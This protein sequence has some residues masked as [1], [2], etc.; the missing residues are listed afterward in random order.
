[1]R[2]AVI[3]VILPHMH[4]MTSLRKSIISSAAVVLMLVGAG[5]AQTAKQVT[6]ETTD[7]AVNSVKVS[8]DALAKA[9]ETAKQAD[10][11]T[12]E[13]NEAASD[14][15]TVAWVLTEGSTTTEQNVKIANE[16][17]GCNDRVAFVKEHRMAETIDTVG[18]ALTTLFAL[19]SSVSHPGLYNSL[20]NSK[21][22]VDKILSPDGV[23]TEVWIAG[24]VSLGGACDA[25]RFKEQIEAT[26]RRFRPNHK[27]FLNGSEANYR[28]V[29]DESGS[30]A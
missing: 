16:T 30:C 20:A 12:N 15:I 6:D 19:G 29:G 1:M 2:L 8:A 13:T 10:A 9:Q 28:C 26:V 4:S 23:T 11:K 21:L 5:C 14:D 3:K 22:K 7:L 18:D 17:F 25:P 24:E 27:I